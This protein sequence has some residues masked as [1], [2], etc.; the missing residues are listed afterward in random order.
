MFRTFSTT[1]PNPLT[2]PDYPSKAENIQLASHIR[3]GRGNGASSVSHSSSTQEFHIINI[4]IVLTPACLPALVH[5][6]SCPLTGFT[7]RQTSDAEYDIFDSLQPLPWVTHLGLGFRNH[8]QASTLQGTSTRR[9]FPKLAPSYFP[10]LRFSLSVGG[11]HHS[12]VDRS[13]AAKA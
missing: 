5:R 1:W 8:W 12:R 11:W 3:P 6:S 10:T 9:I 13:Q 2:A 7:F 4:P